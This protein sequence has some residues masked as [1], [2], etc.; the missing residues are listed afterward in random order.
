M[1][2]FRQHAGPPPSPDSPPSPSPAPSPAPSSDAAPA[3]AP[4]TTPRAGHLGR[5]LDLASEQHGVVSRRG[6]IDQGVPAHV[7]DHLAKTRVLDP[8]H[9]GVYRVGRNLTARGR[10]M[11]AILAC[12]PAAVISH[13][14]AAAMWQLL[15]TRRA[16][17][18]P[19]VV[20]RS[21]NRRRPGVRVRRLSNLSDDEVT[22]LDGIPVRTLLD[23]A[24][25]ARPRTLERAVTEAMARRLVDPNA[26]QEIMARH[27][28]ERGASRFRAALNDDTPALIRSEA[29]QRFLDLVRKARLALPETN[30]VV[31]GHEVDFY[32]RA[33]GLA[34]EMDG[35]AF[36]STRRAFER[37]RRRDLALAAAG[38][39]VVRLTWRR[40]H[41]EPEAILVLLALALADTGDREPPFSTSRTTHG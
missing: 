17:V 37:D 4:R 22:V 23:L 6:L 31:A 21:G 14:S 39:R 8:V 5:I 13:R 15:P 7:V 29:E 35:F 18:R 10:E 1:T 30:V 2:R 36:H 34:V 41:S 27:A 33:R 20:L 11:A 12:G 25:D 32:W 16:P 38:V 26:L 19:E 9:R 3:P 24:D 40:L 28:G